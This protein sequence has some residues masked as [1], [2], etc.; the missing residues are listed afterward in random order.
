MSR[1]AARNNVT[2][3]GFPKQIYKD[4]MTDIR[5]GPFTKL[6]VCIM[7]NISL[8]TGIK[9]DTSGRPSWWGD[10]LF[11]EV[12]FLLP[13]H[14]DDASLKKSNHKQGLYKRRKTLKIYYV[15]F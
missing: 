11:R 5:A 15:V 2:D 9:L 4:M 12:H 7:S 10:F 8:L 3:N 13:L 1:N 6:I 14:L